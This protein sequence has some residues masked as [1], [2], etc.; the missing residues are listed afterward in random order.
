MGIITRVIRPERLS[1]EATPESVSEPIR[2]RTPRC[3]AGRADHPLGDSS[4]LACPRARAG[5]RLSGWRE[6]ED[7]VRLILLAQCSS[8]IQGFGDYALV[9]AKA[10]ADEHVGDV[11]VPDLGGCGFRSRVG[12]K[13]LPNLTASLHPHRPARQQVAECPASCPEGM[14]LNS[15]R[16]D[17]NDA[18]Q[19]AGAEVG[20]FGLFRMSMSRSFLMIET[21]RESL[22]NPCRDSG[23]HGHSLISRSPKRFEQGTMEFYSE[24]P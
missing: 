3:R 10:V 4:V 2:R 14:L 19:E 23:I 16:A 5:L 13:N 12:T 24:V 22:K 11:P 21:F 20:G 8:I 15:C 18:Q 6:P 1:E 7:G 9:G 17:G